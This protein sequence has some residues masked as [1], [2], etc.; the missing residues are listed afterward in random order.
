MPAARFNQARK[1]I[2][3]L[4]P[5]GRR[6]FTTSNDAWF[7]LADNLPAV[8]SI[9]VATSNNGRSMPLASAG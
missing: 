9:S 2:T 6:I 7:I 5:P 8:T 4:S 3:P 1:S